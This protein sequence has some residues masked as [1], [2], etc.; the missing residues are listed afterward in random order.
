M[1]QGGRKQTVWF[2]PASTDFGKSSLRIGAGLVTLASPKAALAVNAAH[3]TSIL[4]AEIDAP[5]A[6]EA[7]LADA[8]RNV[9]LLGPA[10]GVGAEARLSGLAWQPRRSVTRATARSLVMRFPTLDGR[11][12]ETV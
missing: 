7:F 6:I 10:M 1:G 8:R 11:R 12:F 5:Q 4:L 2:W 3:L 9:V